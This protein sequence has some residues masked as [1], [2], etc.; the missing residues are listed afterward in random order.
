MIDSE[1]SNVLNRFLLIAS[2]AL[3]VTASRTSLVISLI[4]WG[5]RSLFIGVLAL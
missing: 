5:S 4:M 1:F 2:Y 3:Y